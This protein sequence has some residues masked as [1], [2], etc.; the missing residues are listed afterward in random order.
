M[1]RP[2]DVLDV[3]AIALIIVLAIWFVRLVVG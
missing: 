3:M 2:V 1:K